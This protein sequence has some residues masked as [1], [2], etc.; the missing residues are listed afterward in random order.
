MTKILLATSRYNQ[1]RFI[2][3]IDLDRGVFE[4]TG[5]TNFMRMACDPD[6]H[7]NTMYDFEGGPCFFLGD[8]FF[9]MGKIT[10]ISACDGGAEVT[11]EYNEKFK[12]KV[13]KVLL[14][15]MTVEEALN[16]VLAEVTTDY[17]KYAD[18][19]ADAFDIETIEK[20]G[21]DILDAEGHK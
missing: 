2:K 10:N 1:P 4:I 12:Q 11:I 19:I 20:M 16:T 3:D 6:T 15:K 17:L 5:K 18:V 9:R 13:K 21:N 7:V 14:G 8:E